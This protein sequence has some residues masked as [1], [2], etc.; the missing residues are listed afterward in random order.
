MR[1]RGFLA[2]A[3]G[4]VGGGLAAPVAARDVQTRS[5]THGF[6]EAFPSTG[7]GAYAVAAVRDRIVLSRG[8]GLAD[9]EAPRPLTV[10]SVVRIAS[11]T[12]QFT[13][14]AT[15]K[16][17][18][19]GQLTLDGR[20]ERLLPDCPPAWRPITLRQLLSQTS[21]VSDDLDPLLKHIDDDLTPDQILAV[22]RDRPLDFEPGTRW[23]YSNLNYWI[24][25]KLIEVASGGP[26]A[27]FVERE[28]LIPRMT[29][30]RYG[31]NAAIIAGRA[32]GYEAD[33][34]GG[35]E[36]ARY[37]SAKLGYAAGGFLSTPRDMATWYG[38]LPDILSPSALALAFTEQTTSD[39]KPTGYGLGWRLSTLDGVRV[40][41]HGGS[42]F[43]FTSYVY[44]D[45]ARR[46]FAGVFRNAS[47]D[48]GEPQAEAR[49]VMQGLLPNVTSGRL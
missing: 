5:I 47:D 12:K 18:E 14:V 26:Y 2:G 15:L 28:V 7:P 16:L 39:G 3:A 1:R 36:N 9:L 8:F 24:I 48:R 22:Y 44:Y 25:G 40:A 35:W 10:D 45:P 32:H 21:G 29:R 6:S 41:H 37:F 11:L 31:D 19:R 20:L 30:T 4:L 46:R 17:I 42:T 43:G 23:R 13:A 33:G 34:K 38:A 49:Q 27:A